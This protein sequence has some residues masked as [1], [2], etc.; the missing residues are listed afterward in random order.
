[1]IAAWLVGLVLQAAPVSDLGPLMEL[2][3]KAFQDRNFQYLLDPRRSIR[4]ELPDQPAAVSVRGRV[5]ASALASMV[6]RSEDVALVPVGAAVVAPGH[7]YLELA[8]H[9]RIRGTQEE[10]RQRILLSARLEDG[11]WQVTEV[12]VSPADRRGR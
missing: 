3:A 2:A 6:R 10:H 4:L 12:W 11:R 5:A 7:G 8:R 9:Y 1:M